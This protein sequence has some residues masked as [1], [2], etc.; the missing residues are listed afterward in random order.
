MA[1]KTL[2]EFLAL[3]ADRP[4][5]ST[6]H[7]VFELERDRLLQVNLSSLLMMKV[8]AM[9][10]YRGDIKFVRE[11]ML[12]QGVGN[13][14]KKAVSGEGASL[15]KATGHGT[16]YLAD[17]GKKITL[18]ALQNESLVVNGSDLL[19]FEP[20][21][22]HDI[23]MVRKLAAFAAGGLFNIHLSGSGVV[24]I[25]SHYDP[26]TLRVTPGSPV[27][28]D[29]NATVCWSG[30][31]SPEFKTDLQLKTFLGR[32]SGESFQMKFDGDGFVV[33]QPFEETPLQ[34]AAKG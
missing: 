34:A 6:D 4:S 8:G 12:D 5:A 15:A 3:S 29:P 31:L 21:I 2:A 9:V 10:A 17:A 27:F 19:A 33:V 14:L 25:T 30:N 28:T 32:G 26:L 20:G 23:H 11:G 7:S 18:L 24:A 1:V 16:L 22:K 13:L